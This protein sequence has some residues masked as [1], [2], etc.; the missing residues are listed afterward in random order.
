M[1]KYILCPFWN[2]LLL[3]EKITQKM[4]IVDRW[5]VKEGSKFQSKILQKLPD[6]KPISNS[7]IFSSDT[8]V[9]KK[10][11]EEKRDVFV[12]IHNIA[13]IEL[14]DAQDGIERYSAV[15]IMKLHA[16]WK[17]THEAKEASYTSKEPGFTI[18][19]FCLKRVE[20]IRYRGMDNFSTARINLINDIT[21]EISDPG[22]YENSSH[23]E[24][25]SSGHYDHLMNLY[26]K[27]VDVVESGVLY[28]PEVNIEHDVKNHLT[29]MR[30]VGDT[31]GEIYTS[32]EK[33]LFKMDKNGIT[34]KAETRASIIRSLGS[35]NQ[36]QPTLHIDNGFVIEIY[37]ENQLLF[38]GYVPKEHFRKRR[39]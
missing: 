28:A 33:T 20:L 11:D 6:F 9:G 14:F 17:T 30:F 24:K 5:V 2:S 34:V 4:G 21:I 25:I 13:P 37:H 19:G 7:N 15:A 16:K 26:R 1:S 18:V 27:D 32:S 22:A 12:S 8:F 31:P 3:T 23:L 35:G 39:S 10:G 36:D 38:I 29:N